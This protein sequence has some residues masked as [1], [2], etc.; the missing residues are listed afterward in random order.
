MFTVFVR[1]FLRHKKRGLYVNR[2]QSR[3]KHT[4]IHWAAQCATPYGKTFFSVM[5][6]LP[7]AES[8][9]L[10]CYLCRLPALTVTFKC[11][12]TNSR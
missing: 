6:P 7:D 5:S 11:P 8:L 10:A 3:I 2:M 1:V 9:L 12:R 4:M